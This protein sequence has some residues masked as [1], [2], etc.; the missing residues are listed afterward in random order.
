MRNHTLLPFAVCMLV[1]PLLGGC[2][3]P[4]ETPDA[5]QAAAKKSVE[6]ATATQS[7]SQKRV[8]EGNAVLDGK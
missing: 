5:E 6:Q 8:D 7:D 1:I 3:K 2:V 4:E